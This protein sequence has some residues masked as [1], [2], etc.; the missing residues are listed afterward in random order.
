MMPIQIDTGFASTLALCGSLTKTVNSG[1]PLAIVYDSDTETLEIYSDDA[2]LGGS[3][4]EVVITAYLI[5]YPQ[6][7][8]V[9]SFFIE[10]TAS[11][12]KEVQ[13]V[14]EVIPSNLPPEFE[15]PLE[16]SL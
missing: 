15:E 10:F 2:S 16:T 6:T 1:N 12:V 13:E 11:E 4:Q 8:A 7:N 9:V 5:D 3:T 14:Q